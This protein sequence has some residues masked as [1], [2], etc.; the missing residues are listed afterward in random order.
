MEVSTLI[1]KQKDLGCNAA[2]V[3]IMEQDREINDTPS[4]HFWKMLGG[5]AEVAGMSTDCRF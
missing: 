3:H 1:V 2:K 5:K 4:K